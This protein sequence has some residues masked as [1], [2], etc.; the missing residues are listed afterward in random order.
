LNVKLPNYL[1]NIGKS[2]KGMK[3]GLV[4]EYTDNLNADNLKLLEEARQW[5]V[6]AGC[7]IVNI[8]LKTTPYVLPAYYIIAPAEA[9]SN[10][11]RYDGVRYG[12]RSEASADIDDLYINSRTEGFGEEVKRRILT[13][14][15]VLSAGY[16]DAYYRHAIKIRK[17]VQD[18]F[19]NNAFCK[20]DLILVPSTP[21]TAFGIEESNQM[22]PVDMYMNDV[23]TVTANIAGIPGLSVPAGLSEDGLPMGVQLIGP[24]LSESEIFK[25]ASIVEKS[26]C[27]DELRK[28]IITV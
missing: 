26:A 18:D 25:V 1:E 20:V 23:F 4:K 7:E 12:H 16:Y 2:V 19:K 5:L 17:M 10:L 3:I 8:S 21:S 24:R 9:S 13:G 6:D 28:D 14:T 11:A 15:Y 27:F 22:T